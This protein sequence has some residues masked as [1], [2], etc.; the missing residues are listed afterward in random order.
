MEIS[1]FQKLTE[2]ELDNYLN[3]IDLALEFHIKWLAELTRTLLCHH[4]LDFNEESVFDLNN[5][6]FNR[7]YNS[8]CDQE[9]LDMPAFSSLN[10]IHGNMLNVA[11][12]LISTVANNEVI[13]CKE[14]DRFTALAA[15][16]RHNI[17]LLKT[18]I[19]SDLKLV[20]KL[21]GKVFENA[22]EGV[23]IT[24]AQ[25]RILNVN[26]SFTSVTQYTQEEVLGKKPSILH[27][28]H[29][30]IGFYQRMWVVLTKEHR[31]QGE[32]WNRRK[33]NDIY[34]E[35]LSITAVFDDKGDVTHYIGIFSDVSTES[36]GNDRL[37]RL[38]HYDSLCNLP[39][40]LLF[41]DRLRQSVSR[42]RR[43]DQR[44]AV[45]FMDLDGF[46]KVNDEHG[47]GVGD[48]L[49]QQVSKRVA[50]VLRESDTIARI[51]GDEFT[52]IINDIDN[53]ESIN[54]IVEKIL[55]SITEPHTVNHA[56]FHISASIGI[57]LYPDNSEDMN[58]LVKQ[59]DIAM[60]K[61]KK[62]GKNCYKFY[63]KTMD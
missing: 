57:S 18:K 25:S 44:I 5:E 15:D 52:L 48:E 35:W 54:T 53:I 56:S 20:A 38:A 49:L 37:Y 63:D 3:D 47:H 27:S 11:R 1:L 14:Y 16:L 32:I 6:Y 36:E 33:N 60:Y 30:D 39:N 40:R 41:Y 10:I 43:N 23:M 50:E 61:A 46:K 34:P 24:D 4:Q 8:V 58:T 62:Q 12:Q 22:E 59:A 26:Q 17:Q 51:G 42:S 2:S 19:K 31:W 9:L 29:H 13:C 7:W 21:M 45:M 55:T 28:G